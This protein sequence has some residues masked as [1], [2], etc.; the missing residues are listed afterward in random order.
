M[1]RYSGGSRKS[2]GCKMHWAS[3]LEDPVQI[4]T[5]SYLTDVVEQ[6][7]RRTKSRVAPRLG[8][9]RFSNAQR[10]LAGVETR[11][12][13]S[14]LVCAR[15]SARTHSRYGITCSLHEGWTYLQQIP[16]LWLLDSRVL[17]SG[18]FYRRTIQQRQQRAMC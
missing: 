5:C 13:K 7:H 18:R 12:S 14:S 2:F 17:V 15:A 9:K 3:A 10:V 1:F 16:F 6:D 4:R 8:F 11:S